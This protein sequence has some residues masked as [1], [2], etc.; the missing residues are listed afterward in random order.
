[1]TFSKKIMQ[2]QLSKNVEVITMINNATL[3]TPNG[4]RLLP[5]RDIIHR[6][7]IASY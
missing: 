6:V 7:I 5:I 3:V 1:M 4:T 2:N